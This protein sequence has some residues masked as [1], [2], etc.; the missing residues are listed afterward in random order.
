M[1]LMAFEVMAGHP[2]PGILRLS[3]GVDDGNLQKKL[4][5]KLSSSLSFFGI[6]TRSKKSTQ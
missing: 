6:K 3:A 1:A 2:H 5:I 4:V